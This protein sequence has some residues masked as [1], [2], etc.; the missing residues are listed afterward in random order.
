MRWNEIINE[1]LN[2]VQIAKGAIMDIVAGLK[3]QGVQ[4]ITV[5]QVIELIR[6]NP[7]FE[8]TTIEGDLINA[9]VKDVDGVSVQP[10]PETNKLSVMI[11]NPTAGRQVDQKQ[12]EKDDK[13]IKSAAMR[14]ISQKDKE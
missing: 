4:S 5:D 9:A 2:P 13:A 1:V 10:D 7:D 8:G 3:A 11:D 12:A 6:N 14:A